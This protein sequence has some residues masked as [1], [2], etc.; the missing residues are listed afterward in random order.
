MVSESV[1]TCQTKIVLKIAVT[2]RFE[3]SFQVKN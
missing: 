1:K 3:K 2:M